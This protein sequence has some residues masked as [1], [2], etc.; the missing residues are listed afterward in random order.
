MSIILHK[1]MI[2]KIDIEKH[3]ELAKKQIKEILS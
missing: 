3:L 2:G 1:K